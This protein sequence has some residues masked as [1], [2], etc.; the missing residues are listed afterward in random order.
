[1]ELVLPS[2]RSVSSN[3][4][5]IFS[6]ADRKRMLIGI[7]NLMEILYIEFVV[8]GP[9]DEFEWDCLIEERV[10]SIEAIYDIARIDVSI[11]H[12]N[13]SVGFVCL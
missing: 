9:E 2:E 4:L 1:M 6:L 10:N 13:C 11:L 5:I 7:T 8:A 12:L 3:D